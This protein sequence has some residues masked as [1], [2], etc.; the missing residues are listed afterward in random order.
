[1]KADVKI[2]RNLL[3]RELVATTRNRNITGKL[4]GEFVED[5]INDARVDFLVDLSNH[6][7]SKEIEAG[8]SAKN[9]TGS[10]GGIGNLFSFIGFKRE[11]TPIAFLKNL[12]SAKAGVRKI[13]L[14]SISRGRFIITTNIP[15]KEEVFEKTP[16]EWEKGRS[17]LDAVEKGMSGLG[18]YRFGIPREEMWKS[19]SRH[20]LQGKEE[21]RSGNYRRMDYFSKLYNKF[22]K[23]FYTKR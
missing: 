6:K 8:P 23:Q 3:T 14:E 13:K 16:L 19:R 2:S 5:A 9:S 7:V 18:Q 22:L 11:D 17:W 1:M 20:A 10:L 12:F 15:S 4:V 21:L